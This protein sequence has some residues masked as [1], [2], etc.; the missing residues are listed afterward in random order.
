MR[1][2]IVVRDLNIKGCT[3]KQVLGLAQFLKSKGH[4]VEIITYKYIEKIKVILVYQNYL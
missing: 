4:N 2:A 3:Q 1:I